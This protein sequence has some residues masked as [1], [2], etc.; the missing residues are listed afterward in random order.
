MNAPTASAA[1]ATA[2]S[3]A[4]VWRSQLGTYLGLLAVLA[5]MVALF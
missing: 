1:P 5:G 3:S 4:S 2:P